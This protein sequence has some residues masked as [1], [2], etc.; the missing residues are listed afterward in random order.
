MLASPILICR[1][2]YVDYPNPVFCS[3]SNVDDEVLRNLHDDIIKGN[4]LK[5]IEKRENK[6]FISTTQW[7]IIGKVT[8]ICQLEKS[9]DT[10]L[11]KE[12][13]GR[14]A[15]GFVGAVISRKDYVAEKDFLDLPD[16]YYLRAYKKYLYDEH[17]LEEEKDCHVPY[18]YDA[19]DVQMKRIHELDFSSIVQN[20]DIPIFSDTLNDNVFVLAIKDTLDGKCVSFCSNEEFNAAENVS[21]GVLTYTTVSEQRI[22]GQIEHYKQLQNVQRHSQSIYAKRDFYTELVKLCNDYGYDVHQ[23]EDKKIKGYFIPIK[24]KKFSDENSY[25]NTIKRYLKKYIC[26]FNGV[27]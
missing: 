24:E 18:R 12:E 25:K 13:G 2:K 21:K 10:S 14:S 9:L 3:P 22:K 23:I 4:N 5:V 17:W 8:E 6:V 11:D 7:I 26:I 16:D 15:W 20:R 19:V 1:T 27:F